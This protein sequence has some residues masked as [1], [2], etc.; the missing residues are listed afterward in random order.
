LAF[1]PNLDRLGDD[2]VAV[3]LHVN[4]ADEALDALLRENLCEGC[5]ENQ[6]RKQHPS[7]LHFKDSSI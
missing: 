2:Q 4:L 7:E 5:G 1:G 6:R 3:A